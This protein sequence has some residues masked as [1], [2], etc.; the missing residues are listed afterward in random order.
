METNSETNTVPTASS[1]WY[2]PNK[3]VETYQS[4]PILVAQRDGTARRYADRGT[5]PGILSSLTTNLG[6]ELRK[7]VPA[8]PSINQ[9]LAMMSD[10]RTKHLIPEDIVED[11]KKAFLDLLLQVT[12]QDFEDDPLEIRARAVPTLS[13]QAQTAFS[14]DFFLLDVDS[15]VSDHVPETAAVGT[16]K[17]KETKARE[18]AEA[19]LTC[20]LSAPRE[21]RGFFG[22]ANGFDLLQFWKN[23]GSSRNQHA[24]SVNRRYLMIHQ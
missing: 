6:I 21:S 2:H 4:G 13:P 24:K 17:S 20:W 18:C 22:Q 23:Y 19:E 9:A 1:A 10:P 16:W 15:C 12:L 11:V 14:P 3:L 5:M 7:Y 8:K